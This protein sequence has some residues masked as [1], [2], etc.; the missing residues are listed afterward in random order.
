MLR[1]VTALTLA[2]L[3][4]LPAS[5]GQSRDKQAEPAVAVNVLQ[6]ALS[7]AGYTTYRVSIEFQSAHVRD[8]YALFG[9]NANPL[10]IP[11]AYQVAAPFGS[12]VGPVNPAFF[13]IMPTAEY[14]SFLTIGL[15]GPALTAGALTSVGYDFSAWTEASGISSEQAAVF[16]IDPEHGATVSESLFLTS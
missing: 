7:I 8:V 6:T 16:F 13:P 10:V 2:A 4:L 12:D 3:A 11:P 1:R 5:I 14:D 15:D 9:E